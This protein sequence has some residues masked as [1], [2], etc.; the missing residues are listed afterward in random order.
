[1][2]VTGRTAPRISRP[3]ARGYVED[4]LAL[5]GHVIVA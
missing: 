1:M 4:S 3:E 5:S 2:L